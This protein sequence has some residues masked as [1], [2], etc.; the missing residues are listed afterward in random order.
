MF[1]R[2]PYK[3]QHHLPLW[4]NLVHHMLKIQDLEKVCFVKDSLCNSLNIKFITLRCFLYGWLYI[5]P[6]AEMNHTKLLLHTHTDISTHRKT[7]KFKRFFSQTELP[8]LFFALIMNNTVGLLKPK[9]IRE[10]WI[11]KTDKL[12]WSGEIMTLH[13]K[14]WL[15]ASL[16]SWSWLHNMR[17]VAFVNSVQIRRW[18]MGTQHSLFSHRKLNNIFVFILNSLISHFVPSLWWVT[19]EKRLKIH[20]GNP[21]WITVEQ[22]K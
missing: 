6:I 18:V 1:A 17:V 4:A 7:T 20:F 15:K 11:I 8:D 14:R 13:H 9:H 5:C 12:V 3:S 16:I 19:K 22:I 10:L 2:G 21:D